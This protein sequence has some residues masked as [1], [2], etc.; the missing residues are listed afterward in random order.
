MIQ[1]SNKENDGGV[2]RR[3]VSQIQSG[4]RLHKASGTDMN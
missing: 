1:G 2:R 3:H 4:R